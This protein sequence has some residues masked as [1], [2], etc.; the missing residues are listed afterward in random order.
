M[1]AAV[2]RLRQDQDP[3]LKRHVRRCIGL[4][5]A[6]LI[7]GFFVIGMQARPGS[8]SDVHGLL[9]ALGIETVLM[10]GI[11]AWHV[12]KI[13]KLLETV[14]ASAQ[15]GHG[16]IDHQPSRRPSRHH[17]AVWTNRCY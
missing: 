1:E 6:G 8:M 12:G 15:T 16:S 10:V 4:Y 9:F 14:Y 11:A 13:R 2:Y 3:E 5:C 7:A 17:A